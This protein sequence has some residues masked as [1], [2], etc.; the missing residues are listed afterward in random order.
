MFVA[1]IAFQL[2]QGTTR[3]AFGSRSKKARHVFAVH[4]RGLS[5]KAMEKV[6]F[7]DSLPGYIVGP[8]GAPGVLLLQEWWGV[9]DIVKAQA[10]ELSAKANV[11]CLVPDLYKGKIGVDAEEASHVRRTKPNM[12]D[13]TPG[14]APLIAPRAAPHL[15][16]CAAPHLTIHATANEP[17]DYL[18]WL[19]GLQVTP[20]HGRDEQLMDNLDFMNAVEEMKAAVAY[21]KAEGSPK[22]K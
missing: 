2:G 1:R 14:A 16:P 19:S 4:A 11:R 12:R 21:L 13:H 3:E 6:S 17:R 10:Q 8:K 15:T 18:P 20:Y 22:V 7:G 5:A 9:N